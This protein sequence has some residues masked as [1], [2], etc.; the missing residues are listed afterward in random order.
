MAITYTL[1]FLGFFAAAMVSPVMSPMFLH[2]VHDR[3]LPTSSFSTKVFLLGVA[4]SALRLGELVGSPIL[5]QASDRFGRKRVLALA[6]TITA[7]GNILIAMAIVRH[8]VWL[9]VLGQFVVGFVGVLLVLAQAEVAHHSQGAEKTRRF[10]LIYMACGLAYVVAPAVGGHL[11]DV[12][13][14]AWASYELPFLVSAAVCALCVVLI[15]WRFPDSSRI[16]DSRSPSGFR[17]T[18]SEICEAFSF[19]PFRTLLIVNFV[20]YLGID[21]VF[22]FNPVYFVQTW[23]FTSSEVGW[24]MSYTSIAMVG[25]QWILVG[26]VSKRWGPR[27]TTAVSAAALAVLLAILVAPERS[28][29]L[30]AVLP[31]VGAAMALA[32]TNM[33][34]LLSNTAPAD[35]QGRMLGVAHSVRVMGSAL[36]CFCGG[37]LA[38]Y[39]AK[40]PILAAAAASLI[41]AA[42]LYLFR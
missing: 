22:Q 34:A 1:V 18:V 41:A 35:A 39:S 4:L 26:P 30:Y 36:L 38:G 13:L 29:W 14:Y 6:M 9:I 28:V 19:R 20:L 7:V 8:F 40:A 17:N 12:S 11:A 32:T 5:G 10:G 33:S 16:G 25:T 15:L 3:I 42:I 23:H 31:A 24:F 21:F 2:P 37:I 27:V